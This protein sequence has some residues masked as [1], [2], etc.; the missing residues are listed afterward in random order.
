MERISRNETKKYIEF[1]LLLRKAKGESLCSEEENKFNDWINE[2]VSHADY[3]RKK[4]I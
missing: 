2:S 4:Q 1:D 3:F